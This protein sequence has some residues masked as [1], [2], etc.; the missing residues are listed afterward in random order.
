[1]AN[2]PH[3]RW[4]VDQHTGRALQE[5]ARARAQLAKVASMVD[6]HPAATA[7]LVADELDRLQRITDG[8]MA[9]R[10]MLEA[11]IPG[12]EHG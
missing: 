3:F 12:V 7:A 11:P 2:L 9:Q 5:L 10:A 8:L 6:N 1:M 4:S